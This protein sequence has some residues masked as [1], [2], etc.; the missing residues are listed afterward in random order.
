MISSRAAHL[1]RPP[2]TISNSAI[3]HADQGTRGR[4]EVVICQNC[5]WFYLGTQHGLEPIVGVFCAFYC[6]HHCEIEGNIRMMWNMIIF[7]LV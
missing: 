4:G 5:V 2:L 1:C 3:V 6:T 7:G